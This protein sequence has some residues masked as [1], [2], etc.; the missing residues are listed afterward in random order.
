MANHEGL[1]GISDTDYL[2]KLAKAETAWTNRMDD[3]EAPIRHIQAKYNP[4]PNADQKPAEYTSEPAATIGNEPIIPPLGGVRIDP[5]TGKEM[6]KSAAAEVFNR[7]NGNTGI[8]FKGEGIRR[9][10]F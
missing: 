3:G 6:G 1:S 5:E 2:K 9:I 8:I 7:P 10:P 4:D